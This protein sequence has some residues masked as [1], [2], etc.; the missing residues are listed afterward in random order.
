MPDTSIVHAVWEKGNLLSNA[1][2]YT[3][4]EGCVSLA[5][6]RQDRS[7]LLTVRDTGVGIPS[8]DLPH[9]F[10]RFYRGD[11]AREGDDGNSELGPI[12]A[13]SLVERPVVAPAPDFG[14]K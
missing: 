14:V 8:E 10:D 5:A 6:A 12:I 3:P 9:M 13:R 7:M 2:R 4:T 11:E 1:L